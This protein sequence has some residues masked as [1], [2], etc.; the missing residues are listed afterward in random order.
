MRTNP[1]TSIVG[2]MIAATALA[3]VAA[4]QTP[5]D[6]TPPQP[7]PAAQPPTAEAAA[8]SERVDTILTRLEHRE[9][10]DL[11]AKVRWET[12]YLT[13][14]PGEEE[15]KFGQIWYLQQAPV[16]KF[17]V[18]FERK[19][20]GSRAE[21]LQEEHLFDG[22]WYVELQGKGKTLTR[23]EIRREGD[24]S[25]PYKLGEGEFPLPFGQKKAD[26]LREF[27]V[28]LVPPA[29][30]DP[31]ETDHLRLMPR[32]ESG[33]GRQ[34]ARLD[35]WIARQGRH[36]GLPVK[37][38]AGK[39]DGAGALNSTLTITFSDIELNGGFSSGV[40]VIEKPPGFEEIVERLDD[41]PTDD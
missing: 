21:P 37:V 28:T 27:D 34:Y 38:Q 16:A 41:K 6:R 22:R 14:E 36:A 4:C 9:V 3:V 15:K 2:G 32:P 18:R 12:A 1:G 10:R 8:Q 25:N 40:F 30:D 17:K 31:A 11:H 7:A 19:V 35:F 5:S 39:K 24:T 33:T 13:D 26:I 23:N 29:S 20:V